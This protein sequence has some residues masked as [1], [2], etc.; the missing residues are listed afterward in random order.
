MMSFVTMSLAETVKK[1]Y[2]FK[3]KANLDSFSALIWIQLMG[4]LLSFSTMG[5]MGFESNGISVNVHYYTSDVVIVFT[6]IW[7]FI[8]AI[9]ITTKPYRYHDFTFIT[10]RLSSSLSNILFLASANLFGALAAIMSHN[11]LQMIWLISNEENFY[12]LQAGV[13]EHAFGIVIAFLYF[14]LFSAAGY[15]VGTLVQVSKA[16]IVILSA[17]VIGSIFFSFF[18]GIEPALVSLYQFYFQESSMLLFFLKI[19]LY[20]AALFAASISIL[21]RL[22]VRK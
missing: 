14:M 20:C 1:Q 21:N 6:M 22:E 13:A 7:S 5:S 3:L 15:F 17:L 4:M 2:F 18:T 11:L 19:L 10:N 9:T 16:F 12:S 8:T